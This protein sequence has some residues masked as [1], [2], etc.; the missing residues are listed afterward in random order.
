[1]KFYLID[2]DSVKA[3]SLVNYNV[4]DE[5]V[6]YAIRE[7]QDVY[8]REILG[9]ALLEKCVELASSGTIDEEGYEAYGELVDKY[10]YQYLVAKSQEQILIPIS[11]K[12]RNI[13]VS[14]DSDTNVTSQQL[15][16]VIDLQNYW[17]SQQLQTVIDLQNYW[18]TIS[19]DRG[20]RLKCFLR[21]NR[22][23]FPELETGSC[24]CGACDNGPD[25]KLEANCN[26]NI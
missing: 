20:N 8:L 13:G 19:I 23:S 21:E 9:N 2:T 7:S 10:I 24:V 22:D 11:F 16:T 17:N 14:Q 1:M 4:E 3:A 26:L 25:L 15:Q 5:A 18:K 6:G 12:I